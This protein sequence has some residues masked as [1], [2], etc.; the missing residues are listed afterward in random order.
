MVIL[1]KLLTIY[2]SGTPIPQV[3]HQEEPISVLSIA[4]IG[5]VHFPLSGPTLLPLQLV[6]IFKDSQ[7]KHFIS[8]G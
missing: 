5:H 7:V 6:Q 2:T 3:A 4:P 8:H 1:A